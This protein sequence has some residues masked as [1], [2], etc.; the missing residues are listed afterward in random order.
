MPRKKTFGN[1]P[2][3]CG[4]GLTV[5]M[6]NPGFGDCI[7]IT[8]PGDDGT[9]RHILIDCGVHHQYPGRENRMRL[10]AGDIVKVTG[11]HLDVVAITHEHTDHLYGFKYA[12]DIFKNVKIDEL[13][14]GWTEN[15]DD[16]VALELKKTIKK[17][18]AD[19]KECIKLTP[20]GGQMAFTLQGLLDFEPLGVD[21]NTS[22]LEFLRNRAVKA[23]RRS[24]D[25][26]VPGGRPLRIPGVKGINI[27]V[28]GPPGNVSA[29]KTLTQENEMYPEIADINGM[30][31]FMS[32]IRS[33]TEVLQDED[34]RFRV[35]S[36]FAKN[37]E[38]PSDTAATHRKYGGF[39]K[40]FY[41]FQETGGEP[42]RRID[43]DWLAPAGELALRINSLTNNTSLVL[44]FE[45]TAV[46]P[47]RVLLFAGD[48]QV[49]NWLSWQETEFQTGEDP[50]Q[51]LKGIDL[52]KRTVLYKAGHHGSRNATLRKKGLELMDDSDLV[53]MIPVDEAWAKEKMNWEHPAENLLTHLKEKAKNRVVRTDRIKDL[54]GDLI[55]PVGYSQVDW[56]GFISRLTW[57]KSSDNLWVQYSMTA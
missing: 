25:Y 24:E 15:P 57:D 55:K 48:A 10:I 35:S 17:G 18:V 3:P 12:R 23:P 31:T 26:L 50:G 40:E 37:K 39:F 6:Y 20:F 33:E 8:A 43:E 51:K 1:T 22:E 27:Y 14:L 44:A 4:S 16:P 19:L 36:P 29:I 45:M 7:L 2:P 54:P 49:G 13:W 28:L 30:A 42:W 11:N 53:V 38:I 32:A 9:S 34:P 56:N 41:G 46:E 47:H 5:R 52:L 21:G